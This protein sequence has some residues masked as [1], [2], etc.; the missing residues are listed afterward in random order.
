MTEHERIAIW[1]IAVIGAV[2]L[3]GFLT[4]HSFGCWALKTWARIYHEENALTRQSHGDLRYAYWRT[5]DRINGK[6]AEATLAAESTLAS[7]IA[8][9]KIERDLLAK[10]TNHERSA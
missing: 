4:M 2:L 6:T 7:F 10:M 9:K 3:G 8:T 5:E 1:A